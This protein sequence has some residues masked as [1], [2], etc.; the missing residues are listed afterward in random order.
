MPNVIWLVTAIFPLSEIALAILKRAQRGKATSE[1][2]GS[3]RLLWLVITASVAGAMVLRGVRA[4]RLPLSMQV[5]AS[6]GLCLLFGGLLLRWVAILSL[7]RMFTVDVAIHSDHVLV[8]TGVYRL[9]RHPSYSGLLLAFA[10]FGILFGNWL[11]LAVLLIPI[12]FAVGYR[13]AVEEAALR[14]AFGAPYSVYCARTK[15]LVP[16][17]F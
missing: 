8:E 12:G 15:R 4:T 11:S 10:G 14:K 16:G 17:L 13:I 6:L 3:M 7:G 5:G 1:D 9:V 2:R